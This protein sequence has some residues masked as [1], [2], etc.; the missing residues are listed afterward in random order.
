MEQEIERAIRTTLVVLNKQ[1]I[2]IAVNKIMEAIGV[3]LDNRN[4]N[5]EVVNILISNGLRIPEE[6]REMVIDK[7]KGTTTI[8]KQKDPENDPCGFF[9]GIELTE[10]CK[11][12]PV[13]NKEKFCPECGKKIIRTS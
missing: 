7:L 8:T 3:N 12:G 9:D 2:D 13:T 11:V 6:Y 10:C 4:T 1:S 5:A